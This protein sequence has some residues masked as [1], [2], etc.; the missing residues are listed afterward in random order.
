MSLNIL[1]KEL[2]AALLITDWSPSTAELSEIA[3]RLRAFNGE[4]NKA[5]IGNIVFDVVGSFESMILEGVDNSD[6]TTLLVLATKVDSSD[7]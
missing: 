2:E 4:P 7:D 5:N 1:K 3:K 6:L